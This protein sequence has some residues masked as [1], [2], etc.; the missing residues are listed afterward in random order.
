MPNGASG[1]GVRAKAQ[2]GLLD[3]SNIVSQDAKCPYLWTKA[4][5]HRYNCNHKSFIKGGFACQEQTSQPLR[6]RYI[7]NCRTTIEFIVEVSGV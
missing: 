4:A 2:F 3:R 5:T 6:L 1:A 7:A